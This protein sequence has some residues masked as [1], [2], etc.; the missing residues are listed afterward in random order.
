MVNITTA[1]AC[2]DCGETRITHGEF[3]FQAAGRTSGGVH[4]VDGMK[5]FKLAFLS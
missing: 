2:G 1:I 5:L 3:N 4:L